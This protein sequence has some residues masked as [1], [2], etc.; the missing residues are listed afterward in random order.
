MLLLSIFT[1]VVAVLSGIGTLFV[2][3]ASVWLLKKWLEARDEN[4][5]KDLDI[6]NTELASQKLDIHEIKKD[7]KAFIQQAPCGLHILEIA[8]MKGDIN[9][10]HADLRDLR[11]RM[12]KVETETQDIKS[13]VD[14][15][16]E[17][18]RQQ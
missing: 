6:Q 8:E 13:C 18:S 7:L 4:R 12:V 14:D 10:A 9:S 11:N 2:F 1:I 5:K 17:D 15:L 16:C 3:P